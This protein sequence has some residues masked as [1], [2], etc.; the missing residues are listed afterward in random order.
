[1]L[2]CPASREEIIDKVKMLKSY[3]I[4]AGARGKGAGN[5]DAY[6]EVIVRVSYLLARFPEIQELDLNP[7]RVLSDGSGALALD[8][9]LRLGGK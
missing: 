6:V 3:F 9:R 7:V 1:M 5:I 8:A 2:L 4:L